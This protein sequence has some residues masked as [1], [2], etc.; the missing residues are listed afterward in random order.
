MSRSLQKQVVYAYFVVNP[1]DSPKSILSCNVPQL[2]LH[3]LNA[4][5]CPRNWV[6]GIYLQLFQVK[7]DAYRCLVMA[8]EEVVNVTADTKQIQVLISNL[9]LIGWKRSKIKSISMIVIINRIK[10]III[11]TVLWWTF[12]RWQCRPVREP[13]E[14]NTSHVI[15]GQYY[16]EE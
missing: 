6:L 14:Q 16:R 8:R 9:S 1:R 4:D 12:S 10:T 3:I 2:Q 13:L 11:S 5:N 15:H 7:V